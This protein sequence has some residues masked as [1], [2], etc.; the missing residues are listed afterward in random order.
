MEAFLDT[1]LEATGLNAEAL[2]RVDD[3]HRDEDTR[4]APVSVSPPSISIDRSEIDPDGDPSDPASIDRTRGKSTG[5][6]T[7]L[8]RVSSSTAVRNCIDPFLFGDF[9]TPA[10]ALVPVDSSSPR[11]GLASLPPPSFTN[12]ALAFPGVGGL[13][14]SSSSRASA[15]SALASAD[16]NLIVS[17][18]PSS[19]EST[20]AFAP[21]RSDP[22]IALSLNNASSSTASDDP[23]ASASASTAPARL[24]PRGPSRILIIR[25]RPTRTRVIARVTTPTSS[26]DSIDVATR[27]PS[28]SSRVANARAATSTAMARIVDGCRARAPMMMIDARARDATRRETIVERERTHTNKNAFDSSA[29]TRANRRRCARAGARGRRA[30]ALTLAR[31]RARENPRPEMDVYS[32]VHDSSSVGVDVRP[33]R[34]GTRVFAPLDR[35][36][37]R[38]VM[39]LVSHSI[40]RNTYLCT[41]SME[42]LDMGQRK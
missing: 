15:S 33:A 7:S 25:P 32:T 1:L 23:S 41:I 22:S 27:L 5:V 30:L 42:R 40:W 16:S 9:N 2:D 36:A 14:P 6:A 12:H 34:A 8:D 35:T 10:A 21:P 11:V 37:T 20:N 26:S 38:G 29:S 31:A 18:P 19:I 3:A 17:N 24:P 4:V 28:R 13:R 39:G